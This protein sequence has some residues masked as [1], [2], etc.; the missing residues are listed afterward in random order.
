M[1]NQVLIA[2]I[3]SFIYLLFK[4]IEMRFIV[5][6]NKPLKQITIDTLVVFISSVIG[7]IILEQFKL[8]EL[9]GATKSSPGAFVNSPD[10]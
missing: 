7:L 8:G 10:F 2:S 6:E 9:I 4:F 5:K 3:I 1:N